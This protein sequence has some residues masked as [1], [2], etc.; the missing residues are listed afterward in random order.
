V[1]DFFKNHHRAALRAE[2]MPEA[3]RAILTK[4]I[5]YLRLLPPADVTELEARVRVFLAEKQFEGCGGLELTDEMKVTI[6]GQACLL[7]LHRDDDI[8]PD[9]ESILVYPH[10]YRVPAKHRDG[11]VVVEEDE[12]R[13]GESWERGTLVLAWDHVNA[14]THHVIP[15]HNVVLHEFAHQLDGEDGG[16]DGA[17]DL[18]SRAR[19]TAWARVLGDEYKELA[20]RVVAGRATDIDPYAATNPSEFFAVVTEVFFESPERLRKR[21]PAMYAELADFYR[22]DPAALVEGRPPT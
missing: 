10:A 22:Q 6:A 5:P 1:F 17:P 15:G 3:W 18:G 19:Y 20:G 9:L 13:L 16:M 8:Y 11:A 21:H 4:N 7:V 12:V 14:A 2:P